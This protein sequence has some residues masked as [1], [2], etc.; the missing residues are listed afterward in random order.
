MAAEGFMEALY[1]RSEQFLA[2]DRAAFDGHFEDSAVT[3][4]F[5]GENA[6]SFLSFDDPTDQNNMRLRRR[7]ERLAPDLLP[8]WVATPH[9]TDQ[10]LCLNCLS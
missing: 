9:L 7:C 6:L 5:M 3:G 2:S 8:G 4:A 10:L 1:R